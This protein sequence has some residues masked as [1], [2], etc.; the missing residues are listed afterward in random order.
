MIIWVIDVRKIIYKEKLCEKCGKKYTPTSSTQSWCSTC[1]EKTCEYCGKTYSVKKKS[2]YERSR[3]C[4]NACQMAHMGEIQ[5]GENH[6]LYR[7][8]NRSDWVSVTCAACGKEILR[9]KKQAE[10]WEKHF[11]SPECRGDYQKGR[12]TGK[13]NPKYARI[14]KVCAWCGKVFE[15]WPCTLGKVRFCSMQCRNDWQSDKMKGE[16]HHNW[17]GGT[18][19][20]RSCDMA[21]REYKAWRKSVF[22][23]DGYTCRICGDDKGGNLNAHHIKPYRD[24]PELRYEVSNGVTLC[25]ACH[26]KIH[27][28]V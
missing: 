10:R 20:K 15:T 3:F 24:Y 6:P 19:E 18:A 7:S 9:E 4:S 22:E 8:G 25:E 11:C 23:R 1:L 2:R 5:L 13:A 12:N 17:K 27:R 16:N 26:I 28:Q 14:E 21:S